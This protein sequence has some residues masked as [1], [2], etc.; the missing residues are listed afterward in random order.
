MLVNNALS[1]QEVCGVS[2]RPLHVRGDAG[3]PS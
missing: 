3:H 2:Q 1:S